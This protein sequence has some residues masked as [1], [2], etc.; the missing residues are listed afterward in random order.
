MAARITIFLAVAAPLTAADLL[1]KAILPT[2][3][4]LFHA[5]SDAWQLA[6]VALV[7]V[8]AALCRLPSRL[9]AAAAGI[10]AAGIAGNVVSEWSDGAVP[11]PFVAGL[12]ALNLADVLLV[13]GLA[14]LGGAGMRLAT[15]HR[16]LLPTA[17]IPVRIVRSVRGRG[18]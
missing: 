3:P 14:L 18:A 8:A 12:L 2:D 1:T 7:A 6:S 10:F 5:R 4:D 11:N 16:H 9:L 13:A 17:T 15:Q